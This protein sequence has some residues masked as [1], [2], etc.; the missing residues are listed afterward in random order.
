VYLILEWI[1]RAWQGE[2]AKIPQDKIHA[3]VVKMLAINQLI[4]EHEGGNEFH[5]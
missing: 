1:D 4:I 3:M 2:W 5:G